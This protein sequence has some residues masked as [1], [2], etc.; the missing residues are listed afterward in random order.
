MPDYETVNDIKIYYEE[1]GQGEP[2]LFIHGFGETS[3]T[4]SKLSPELSK[5]Y[6]VI[7]I[8]LMGFGQS[9]KPVDSSLYTIEYQAKLVVQFIKQKGLN[10]VTLIGHSYGGGVTMMSAV[11]LMHQEGVLKKLVM[12]GGIAYRMPLPHFIHMLVIPF[13]SRLA[14]ALIPK[15]RLVMNM[16]RVVYYDQ[17]KVEQSFVEAYARPLRDRRAQLA[18]VYTARLVMPDNLDDYTCRYRDIMVPALMI[19]GDHDAVVPGSIGE[20]LSQDLPDARL[21]VLRDCGHVPHE[22]EPEKTLSLISNFL[23]GDN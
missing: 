22:E 19:W 20:R 6:R 8:D 1:S 10:N 17:D 7:A 9:D 2:L 14:L 3:Y 23:Q 18:L 4:W 15:R 21:E 16:F 11:M 13:L 5:H 12:I